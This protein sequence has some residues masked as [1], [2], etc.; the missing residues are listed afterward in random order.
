M[1]DP[2]LRFAA[3]SPERRFSSVWRLWVHGSDAYLGARTLLRW[4]K[5]S[6]HQTGPDQWIAAFT[7]E[8]GA[9]LEGTGSRR[10]RTWTRP[11][12][13]TPGWTQGPTILVPWV[14]WRGQ[15]QHLENPPIDT[16]WVPGPARKRKLLF[17]VLFSAPTV[18][19]DGINLVSEP[20]D[21]IVGSLPLSNGET[22]W[23]QARQV[24]IS[25]DE[26]K[27]IASTE[28]EF[29]GFT[30]SGDA[31]AIDPWGVVITSA[32]GLPL[33]VQLRLGHQHFQAKARV[34]P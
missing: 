32:Q 16:V 7:S 5:L 11:P 25:S 17:I 23:L 21:R 18:P 3:G 33:L 34:T 2:T 13:F 4:L 22:V 6:L 15:L 10:H 19:P 20:G 30:V 26:R 27:H 28:R 1:P 8:S 31:E 14:K 12:E 24:G 9:V 29:R